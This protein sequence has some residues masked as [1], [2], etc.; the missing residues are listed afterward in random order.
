MIR[1]KFKCNEVSKRLGWGDNPIMYAA[2]FSIVT[3]GSEEN[4]KFFA[5]SP[6]GSIEVTTVREDHFDVGKEYYVDFTEFKED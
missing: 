1:A 2:K 6:G 3:A 4:R 5:A